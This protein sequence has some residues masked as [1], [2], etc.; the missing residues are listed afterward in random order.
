MRIYLAVLLTLCF[1]QFQVAAADAPWDRAFSSDTKSILDAAKAAQVPNDQSILVL[2]EEHLFSIDKQ[3]RTRSVYRRVYRVLKQDAVDDWAAVE[4][5]Y[6]PWLENKPELRARV[7]TE[8]GAVHALDPSTIAEA[9]ARQFDANLFSDDRIVTA[10]LPAVARG[11]VVE[12]QVTRQESATALQ[13]GVA[14]RIRPT[15]GVPLLR[16]HLIV[17]ADPAINF[18]HTARLLPEQACKHQSPGGKTRLECDAGPM[19]P[20]KDQEF[21]LPPDVPGYAYV[22][23]STGVSWQAVASGYAAIVERQLAGGAPKLIEGVELGGA[24]ADV[25]SRMMARLHERVRYT[26]VEFGEAAIVPN[27]PEETLKRRYG[28]CKDK[29]ALLVAMLRAAGL[30]ASLALLDAGFDTD[31]EADTPGIGVFN[32]AIVHVASEPPL[33][34]DATAEKMR[35]GTLPNSVGGRLALIAHPSTTGLVKIPAP[36]SQ[37][38][39]ERHTIEVRMS[40]FGPGRFTETIE[41]GGAREADLRAVYTDLTKSRESFENYVKQNYAG[42]LDKIDIS[43]SSDYSKPYRILVEA[44]DAARSVTGF[45]DGAVILFP[46]LLFESLPWDML[47]ADAGGSLSS[48]LQKTRK[49]DF[50]FAQPYRYETTY[51]ILPP[52]GYKL[53]SPPADIS[54]S[55]GSASYRRTVSALKDG[56]IEI[57]YSF[58]SGKRRL[59]P[60]EYVT[61]RDGVREHYQRKTEPLAFVPESAE[62][63]ATGQTANAVAS[64]RA[65]VQKSQGSAMAHARLAR[66]LTASGIGGAA[67]SEARKAVELAP[68]SSPAWQTLAWT[69]EHDLFGRRF[70]AGWKLAEAEK[71]LRKARELSPE[72]PIAAIDLA[73][74]L[75]HDSLGSRY[76]GGARLEEAIKIYRELL[77]KGPNP[78]V[79]QNLAMALLHAGHIDQAVAEQKRAGIDSQLDLV[80]AAFKEG[81]GRAILAAQAKSP[82][83]AQRAQLLAGVGFVLLR[84]RR[85]ETASALMDAVARNDNQARGLA[86]LLSKVKRYEDTLVPASDPRFPVQRLLLE[87]MRGGD[88][89]RIKP[90][91]T[92]RE[93][94]NADDA[95]GYSDLA[96]AAATAR[97]Q[98][99]VANLTHE[100]IV[101]VAFSLASFE[102]DN[103]DEWLHRVTA[104]VPGGHSISPLYVIREGDDYRVLGSASGA[105]EHVARFILDAL[106]KGDLKAAQGWLDKVVGDLQA[107]EDGTGYPAL[108]SLWSGPAPAPAAIKTIVAVRPGSPAAAASAAVQTNAAR[109][110]AAAR[111]AAYSL[112]GASIAS[113]EAIASIEDARTKAATEL[114]RVA[115]DKALCDALARA[116]QWDRMIAPAKRLAASKLFPEEGFRYLLAATR[117]DG[118]WRELELAARERLKASPSNYTAMRSMALARFRQND[119]EGAIEWTKKLQALEL[120]GMD[121][122]L[123]EAQMSMLTGK[124][125]RNAILD[126]LKKKAANL[127]PTQDYEY[128]VAALLTYLD[129]PD[130]AQQ[131]LRSAIDKGPIDPRA[132][133]ILGRIASLYGL[134]DEAA[135]S[136][137]RAK[138]AR[139]DSDE[140]AWALML[141]P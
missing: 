47:I 49:Q 66:V 45:D 42:K 137:E 40:E 17:E 60:A 24:P 97:K 59:S 16:F 28:D 99:A 15:T 39:W 108:R 55:L 74:L 117:N 75:E 68:D 41:A 134:N 139:R 29:S 23:F 118:K 136:Y 85:Y 101:D 2:L 20:R 141:I 37:D 26:G 43:P 111:I 4:Q 92:S 19:E 114:D 96:A 78:Q 1:A 77:A 84:M 128:C 13:A 119:P 113:P 115:L 81:A 124:G 98:F 135:A 72:D 61:L 94:W 116:K 71:A 80:A 110:A 120:A 70:Q 90:L 6:Q 132:W 27:T 122:A 12:Y 131:A 103:D 38:N 9:P 126:K 31:V 58:D 10:P 87:A 65:A 83:P 130:E 48:G 32:H 34:I 133:V 25:A 76:G 82:D 112:L 3:G 79:Q 123:F 18:R 67:Q 54:A 8:D 36:E 33:W 22:A 53:S 95:A 89:E 50:Y 104:S 107:R 52:P 62:L 125:D 30:K 105:L 44:V 127:A 14:R 57:A 35:V 121:E 91:I 56:G 106:A 51:R 102:N 100:N 63:I 7:I 46:H 21:N 69:S 64:A 11:A 93:K 5:T 138:Q 129:K 88:L 109:G 86:Q 140:T 73:I